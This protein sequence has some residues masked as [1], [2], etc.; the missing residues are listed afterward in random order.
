MIGAMVI[1]SDP[2]LQGVL[3]AEP[4][5]HPVGQQGQ[6]GYNEAN[7]VIGQQINPDLLFR[8]APIVDLPR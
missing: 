2:D 1:S 5:R 4:A 8:A 6:L 3:E 7:E